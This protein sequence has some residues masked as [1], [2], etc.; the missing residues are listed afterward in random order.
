MEPETVKHPICSTCGKESPVV[1]RVVIDRE[2][3]RANAKALYNCP[4]CFQKKD[5][6]RL[7]TLEPVGPEK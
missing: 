2:Y 6:E 1:S 4:M 5:T 3:N 7:E